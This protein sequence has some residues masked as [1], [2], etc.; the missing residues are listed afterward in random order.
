[1]NPRVISVIAND[2]YTLTLT[3]AN[4]EVKVYDINPLLDFGVFKELRDKTYFRKVF[5]FNGTIQWPNEQDICPDTL[6]L[7]GRTIEQRIS[8]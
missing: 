4:G 1:M 2:D 6:Y 7:D 8:A 5:V 3:F